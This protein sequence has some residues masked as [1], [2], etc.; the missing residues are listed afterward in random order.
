MAASAA[1]G[2][3][4]ADRT[5][6]EGG[7]SRLKFLDGWRL[8]AVALVIVQ[9]YLW[10]THT[11]IGREV[12]LLG[13]YGS[14]GVYIFFVISGYVISRGVHAAIL[15]GAGSPIRDFYVR[16]FFRILPPL[17]IYALCLVVLGQV[18]VIT[19]A[20]ENALCAATFTCNLELGLPDSTWYLEHTWSLGF[21]EQF[22]L[23]FPVLFMLALTRLGTHGRK[24]FPAIYLA[25]ILLSPICYHF[26][27]HDLGKY[28][29]MFSFMVIGVCAFLYS[30]ELAPMFKRFTAMR[31][32][33]LVL[34]VALPFS[35]A[36]SVAL[37]LY[38]ILVLPVL[39]VFL[40]FAAAEIPRLKS[41]L[42]SPLFVRFGCASY[43]IYLWQQL[44]LSLELGLSPLM[45]V[46]AVALVF[47]GCLLS[48]RYVEVPLIDLGRR[49]SRTGRPIANAG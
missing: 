25:L 39:L 31:Y 7:M 13:A 36:H 16:R 24:A 2:G 44:A 49:F 41:L 21:E 5:V 10:Y 29:S 32:A 19:F 26:K 23:I 37:Q 15:D 17:F 43:G 30:R 6:A 45:S 1:P 28:L 4:D 42:E 12:R 9:H 35:V 27:Y 14:L 8:I 47:W 22:Y 33:L 18:G 34:L 40:V 20:P 38:Q 3:I 11:D 46:A 48:Y